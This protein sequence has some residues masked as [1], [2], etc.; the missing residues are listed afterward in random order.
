MTAY[1]ITHK[2]VCTSKRTKFLIPE[3]LFLSVQKSSPYKRNIFEL[4][5]H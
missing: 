5:F 1:K 4:K 3:Y 2:I